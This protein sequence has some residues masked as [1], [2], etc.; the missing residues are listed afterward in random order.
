MTDINNYK[1]TTLLNVTFI[2]KNKK[3]IKDIFILMNDSMKK[4]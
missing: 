3:Y 1:L 4:I 2:R